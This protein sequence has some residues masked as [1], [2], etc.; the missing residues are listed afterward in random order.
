MKMHL[1]CG[2]IGLICLL[3]AAAAIGS[4]AHT[5]TVLYTFTGGADGG[6][7][8]YGGLIVDAA[9]GTLYGTTPFGGD[10]H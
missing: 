9:E 2:R 10:V 1:C 6:Y 5:F 8:A 4:R 3:A 7:A